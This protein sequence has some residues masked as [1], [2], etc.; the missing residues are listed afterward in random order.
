MKRC[1]A[2][3]ASVSCL[4]LAAPAGAVVNGTKVDPRAWTWLAPSSAPN[5]LCLRRFPVPDFLAPF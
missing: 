1:L 2:I 3:V 4:T 5:A